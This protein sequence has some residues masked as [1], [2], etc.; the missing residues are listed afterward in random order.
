MDYFSFL[1]LFAFN[2][3]INRLHSMGFSISLII[4]FWDR[5]ESKASK[6]T[7]LC[8]YANS[9][10]FLLFFSLPKADIIFGWNYLVGNIHSNANNGTSD[11]FLTHR[12]CGDHFEWH[13]SSVAS[14][15]LFSFVSFHFRIR[16]FALFEMHIAINANPNE[17][18]T[19]WPR[20][21]FHFFL[22]LRPSV[23]S[24]PNTGAVREYLYLRFINRPILSIA[25]HSEMRE[26]SIELIILI[27]T[28]YSV[29]KKVIG[30]M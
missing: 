24:L 26:K 27:Y 21:F 25:T 17:T 3:T 16:I 29:D 13:S 8:C 28:D 14:H 15:F 1:L 12:K 4:I 10:Q 7:F 19:Q 6:F 5:F 18:V 23:S 9:A 2:P 20:H 11:S 22:A 30:K